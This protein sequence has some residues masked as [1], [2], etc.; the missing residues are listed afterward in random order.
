MGSKYYHFNYPF[1]KV[2]MRLRRVFK[3]SGRM[4]N[5]WF[6]KY[7]KKLPVMTIDNGFTRYLF[8]GSA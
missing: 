4:Y 1:I 8:Y 2:F 7:Q 5:I 6:G 3:R